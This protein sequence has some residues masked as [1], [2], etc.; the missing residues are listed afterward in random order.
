MRR[1]YY[2]RSRAA[3]KRILVLIA[4]AVISSVI[5]LCCSIRAFASSRSTAE[6]LHKYYTSICVEKGDSLWSIAEDYTVDGVLSREEFIDEVCKLNNISDQDSL[7]SGE[8]LVV[9]YYSTEVK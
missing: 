1:M 3:Q 4:L 7:R 9:M 8:H 6:P 5:I 2:T